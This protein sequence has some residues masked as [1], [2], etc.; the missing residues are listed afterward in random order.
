MSHSRGAP[1][2]IWHNTDGLAVKS[3]APTPRMNGKMTPPTAYLSHLCAASAKGIF[4]RWKMGL[5]PPKLQ[6]LASQYLWCF[7]PPRSKTQASKSFSALHSAQFARSRQQDALL[8]WLN[9]SLLYRQPP[10]SPL[11][12][13]H[14]RLDLTP[15]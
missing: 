11:T 2:K 3:D 8:R 4:R 13:W 9:A 7:I 15:S 6:L 5:F 12:S 10:P 14:R 1:D